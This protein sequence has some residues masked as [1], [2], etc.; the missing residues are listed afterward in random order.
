MR[1]GLFTSLWWEL[2]AML[3][4]V[5]RSTPWTTSWSRTRMTRRKILYPAKVALL[6]NWI[7]D[8]GHEKEE[9]GR[10][11]REVA[12]E[13]GL[14]L[15]EIKIIEAI[16]GEVE[17][18][19]KQG[20]SGDTSKPL[21]QPHMPDHVSRLCLHFIQMI[22]LCFLL[23]V[24]FAM[25]HRNSSYNSG[26][27]QLSQIESNQKQK[28]LIRLGPEQTRHKRPIL[29]VVPATTDM[30]RESMHY[31]FVIVLQADINCMTLLLFYHV[32]SF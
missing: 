18:D 10:R 29:F 15:M 20:D 6:A 25:G 11:P 24:P 5:S 14:S 3:V 17:P 21:W 32:I 22:C 30:L 16:T 1:H 4:I 31:R 8:R 9:R 26:G 23:T 27:Q 13:A 7:R 12:A 28:L 19:L 2:E